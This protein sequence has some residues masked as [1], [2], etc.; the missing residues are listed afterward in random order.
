MIVKSMLLGTSNENTENEWFFWF[1]LVKICMLLKVCR[2]IYMPLVGNLMITNWPK[3]TLG[4]ENITTD[5]NN[6]AI[7]LIVK[8]WGRLYELIY[9]FQ[10][11]SIWILLL[12]SFWFSTVSLKFFMSFFT[13][14]LQLIFSL[15]LPFLS[16]LSFNFQFLL[17]IF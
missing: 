7:T 3:V 2:I 13:P 16:P 10:W 17:M 1:I 4:L 9:Q 12:Y 14:A 11:S 15:P 8:D 6:N 5:Y